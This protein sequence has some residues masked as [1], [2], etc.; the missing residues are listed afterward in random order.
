MP[1]LDLFLT[2]MWF[3]LFV[4]WVWIVVWVIIDIFR[5]H[6]L[7]GWAKALW[8]LLVAVIPWLGVL[9]YLI[10]RGKPMAERG[11]HWAFGED[12]ATHHYRQPEATSQTVSAAD[13]LAKL[14]KL[15]DAGVI[16]DD[17]FNVEKSKV[18]A[19]S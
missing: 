8:V 12:R 15:R 4:A 19:K 3:F 10:A 14:A 6:D 7:S 1:L 5:S 16:T 11:R 9:I 18:L 2:V 13:E 17:E